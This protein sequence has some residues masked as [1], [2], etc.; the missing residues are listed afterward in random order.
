MVGH[1][2]NPSSQEVEAGELEFEIIAR[3][4][5]KTKLKKKKIK[6]RLREDIYK[7]T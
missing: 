7:D 6:H 5:F 3:T 1:I 4:C 2:Y